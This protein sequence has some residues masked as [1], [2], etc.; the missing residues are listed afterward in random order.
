MS[1]PAARDPALAPDA[2]SVAPTSADGWPAWRRVAIGGGGGMFVGMGLGRFSY[3]AM[4]PALISS[5]EL[6]A[7]E[8]GRVGTLN[9]AGFAFGA[10]ISVPLRSRLKEYPA[11]V[12]AICLSVVALIA[13]AAPLGFAWL[14][15]WR[16]VVGIA[17][18][19]IMVLSLALIA[20]T[21]PAARRPVAASFVFAGVGLGILS[22]G[23]LVPLFLAISIPATWLGL[24]GCAIGAALAAIWGWRAAPAHQSTPI[25][26]PSAAGRTVSAVSP[27][28]T[29]LRLLLLGHLC[30]SMAIV[31]H[32]LYWVDYIAR[33]LGHG[34]GEGGFH[35]SLVGIASI[36]GPWI[37]AWLGL[38]LGTAWALPVS[39]FALGIGIAAPLVSSTTIVLLV[40]SLLF[41]AQ[42]GLSALMAARTRDLAEADHM[43][44]LMR[45][46]I[47]TSSLGAVAA[48]F[49]LPQIYDATQSHVLIFALGGAS[50]ILGAVLVAPWSKR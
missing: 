23:M 22:A 35:W 4:V 33:G 18:G 38:M 44:R 14:G 47:L 32:T 1:P 11:L 30:F 7:L 39:F 16:C 24:G 40:S 41:G 10:L 8:A 49:V 29:P 26:S 19:V 37:A 34:I 25:I 12:T 2:V 28:N 48:G 5:G 50:M 21:A 31:P 27:W 36:L 6:T 13:S 20:A 45:A 43:P 46:M 3:T 9:I 15:F 42:P 17:A